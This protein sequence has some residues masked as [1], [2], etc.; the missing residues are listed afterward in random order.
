MTWLRFV[1]V[2]I[3]FIIR[4]IEIIRKDWLVL[5]EKGRLG[6]LEMRR[7]SARHRRLLTNVRKSLLLLN[8]SWLVRVIVEVWYLMILIIE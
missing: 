5:R 7:L 3:E 6:I 4:L 1:R 2:I 8:K